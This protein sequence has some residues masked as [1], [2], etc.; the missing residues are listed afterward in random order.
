MS[1]KYLDTFDKADVRH[2]IDIED[3]T[4]LIRGKVL[5]AE[6][7]QGKTIE[8]AISDIGYVNMLEIIVKALDKMS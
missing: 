2:V 4:Q 3:F 7:P 8:I 5:Q 1:K 6:T